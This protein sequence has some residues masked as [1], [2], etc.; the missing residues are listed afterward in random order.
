[1][2]QFEFCYKDKKY[3]SAK[4]VN[5]ISMAGPRAHLRGLGLVN[6]ELKKPFIGVINTY[7]EMH[8][9]HIH[10]DTIGT[11]VKN[12]VLEA[13]GIPFEVNTI[14]LC[15]GF[16]QGHVGMCSVLPSREIIADSIEVYAGGHQLDG[17][18]LIG[19]CDKIVPA[20]I[21]AALR[22]NLPA[23]IVT[24]G[25]MMPA[26]YKD[27]KYATYELKEMTGKLKNGEISL[28]EYE[29]MEGLMSP[30]PGSCAMM[31]TAN[32]MS[33]IAE[34]LGL[35]MPG[36]GSAHAISGKKKRI[37]KMSGMRI[38]SLVEEQILP[39]D[40]VT[41]EMLVTA[42]RVGVSVGGSTNMTLHMPAIAH[43][44]GLQ[45]SLD[46]I[47]RISRETPCIVKI[48]PSGT[49]TMWDLEQA[50]GVGAVLRELDGIVNLDQ[51]TVSGKTLRE[52]AEGTY[53]HREDVVHSLKN[54]Y[55]NQG[56]LA[57]LKGNLAPDGCVVKQTAVSP[58]MLK[59][60]GPARCFEN[61]EEAVEAILGQTIRH[62]EVILIRNEGPKGGP[63]M[64][65]M[66]TA[67]AALVSMGYS[68]TVALITDGRFSGATRGPCIGH[69]SPEAADRG[70]IAAVRDGDLIEIDI[71]GRSLHLE[72]SEDMIKERLSGLPAYA[73]KTTDGYLA[74]YSRHVTS[75]ARGAILK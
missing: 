9:G 58:R 74:R 63:G 7:N 40:I 51:M 64:R 41:Q 3:P 29:Y 61:E 44:A 54:A 69:V 52:Y 35:T 32:T 16:A 30:S 24:G 33:L 75:A 36:C 43:E 25:A 12:G 13:G 70:P 39:R 72:V 38:V 2:D 73:P 15:D 17:L 19:G 10:L 4:V 5:G 56:S 66:L 6:S 65:E 57:V 45:M 22:V 20:M 59:H 62:G 46:D 28:E 23:I 48:K 26:E 42:M 67:T 53:E 8:P 18:V 49:H 34:A 60:R 47:E 50:G 27:N 31:G 71:E 1:M 37:A 55:L 68:E 14:S 21:M 11:M